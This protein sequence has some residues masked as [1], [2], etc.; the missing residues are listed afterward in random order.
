MIP[1]YSGLD[2]RGKK[3]KNH[4]QEIRGNAPDSNQNSF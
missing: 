3:K 1:P 2:E 4:G